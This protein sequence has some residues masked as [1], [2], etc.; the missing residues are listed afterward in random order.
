[1]C[2]LT[3]EWMIDAA[4]RRR[5]LLTVHIRELACGVRFGQSGVCQSGRWCNTVMAGAETIRLC[6]GWGLV[7]GGGGKGRNGGGTTWLRT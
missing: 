3:E 5:H 1:M 7:R 6:L 2:T 4:V